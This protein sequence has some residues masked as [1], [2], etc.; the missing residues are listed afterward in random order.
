M[1]RVI[2]GILLAA[3][4]LLEPGCAARTIRRVEVTGYCGCE[5]CAGW[6][7]GS[8]RYLRLDFWNKYVSAGPQEGRPYSG[9]TAAGT[10]PR[11]PH[12]G[13]VSLNTLT[14]PWK[15]PLRLLLPW[16]WL[17]HDGTIAA[18]TRHYPFG[19][20]FHVPGYGKGVV[21]DRGAAIR[22]PRRLDLYFKS[23]R[24]AQRWGRRTLDVRRLR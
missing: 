23:H 12:P 15:L 8:W 24:A 1:R 3:L 21:E 18:D 9:R 16:L 13:L 4:A 10:K 6:E 7:R 19:T 14:H 11:M 2:A 22:G 5:A 17:A 20:R